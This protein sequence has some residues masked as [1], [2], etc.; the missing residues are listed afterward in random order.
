MAIDFQKTAENELL[1]EN[2]VIWEFRGGCLILK[3]VW[4][5]LQA[6]QHDTRLYDVTPR[7]IEKS[8]KDQKQPFS[9][10]DTIIWQ[11]Q[12]FKALFYYTGIG[13]FYNW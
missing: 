12:M 5:N 8:N 2:A 1:L 9:E 3:S 11:V 13:S 7:V 10:V 4:E 6:K